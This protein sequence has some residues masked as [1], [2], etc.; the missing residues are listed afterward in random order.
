[1]IIETATPPKPPTYDNA[2]DAQDAVTGVLYQNISSDGE[3]LPA[4]RYWFE[5]YLDIRP[6]ADAPQTS[7]KL[8]Q[9]LILIARFMIGANTANMSASTNISEPWNSALAW[10]IVNP[11]IVFG[12]EIYKN[13]TRYWADSLNYW[14]NEGAGSPGWGLL[15]FT[16]KTLAASVPSL[17]IG[18]GLGA[19]LAYYGVTFANPLARIVAALIS[20]WIFVGTKKIIDYYF[21]SP[22]YQFSTTPPLHPAQ[23]AFILAFNIM[24]AVNIYEFTRILIQAY[25]PEEILHN[26]HFALGIIPLYLLLSNIIDPIAFGRSP[27]YGAP[28][29]EVRVTREEIGDEP[30]P[31]DDLH[32]DSA[33]AER[34]EARNDKIKNSVV[35]AACA[36]LA[37]GAGLAADALLSRK[38]GDTTKISTG[39]RKLGVALTCAATAVT[40]VATANAAPW[41]INT[42]KHCWASFFNNNTEHNERPAPPSF[43]PRAP[44]TV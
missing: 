36:T 11:G 29:F 25:G 19:I 34:A 7:M 17:L 2:N 3:V 22:E 6:T 44:V 14:T 13:L 26:P 1:M 33:A 18:F 32:F 16:T 9:L 43:S 37:F 4:D 38:L 10:G 39:A 27:L 41:V 31:V 20:P 40:Q 42:T 24:D 28:P 5:N 35:Y 23:H 15:T 8:P 30:L 21:P 12:T